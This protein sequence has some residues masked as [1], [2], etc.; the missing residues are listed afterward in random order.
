MKV[1]GGVSIDTSLATSIYN[2]R[3]GWS[4]VLAARVTVWDLK[5]DLWRLILP[6]LRT[7]Y[8]SGNWE[9]W[10]MFDRKMD[11]GTGTLLSASYIFSRKN[12]EMQKH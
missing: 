12:D 5:S 7:R 6:V 3:F 8:V 9:L 2:D 10:L 11:R 4:D 1:A